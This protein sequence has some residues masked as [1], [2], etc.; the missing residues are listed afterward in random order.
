MIGALRRALAR[1]AASLA[2]GREPGVPMGVR[3][4]AETA[5]RMLGR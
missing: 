1:P 3:L 4:A 2:S 5:I